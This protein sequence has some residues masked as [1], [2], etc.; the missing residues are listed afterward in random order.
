VIFDA[1]KAAVG[2]AVADLH[3]VLRELDDPYGA[4][5]ERRVK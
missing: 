5:L 4:Q 3:G 2:T 1:D